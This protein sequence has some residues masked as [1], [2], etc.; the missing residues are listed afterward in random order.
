MLPV[1]PRE[2]PSFWQAP[3]IKPWRPILA[4]ILGGIGFLLSTTVVVG[5]AMLIESAISGRSVFELSQVLV[6]GGITPILFL[7][8]SASLAVLV[9][10]SLILS[11]LVGQKGG[12]LSSV[13][14]RVRWGWLAKCFLVSF[15]A[16]GALIVVST[17]LEGWDSLELSVRP[18]WWWL[19][20]GIIIVTPFQAAGE[21]YL[22]RGVLNRGIASLIPPRVAGAVVGGVVSSVVFMLL[23]GAGDVWLNITYFS[24]GMLFSYLTWRT[25]G[26]EAAVA[27]HAANNL[28]ALALLPFQDL[29]EVF[30]RSA[31]TGDPTVLLQ[32]VVLGAAAAVIVHMARRRRVS[33]TGAPAAAIPGGITATVG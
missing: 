5:V 9:P 19:L 3:G 30:N 11:R 33:R 6:D 32:L 18:G 7:A 17:T 29:N 1:E 12:W 13:V 24:M 10:L 4:I 15:G 22:I 23:H 21:E 16:I 27:M 8:N 31:G 14:G 26:L 2:Y 28:I 25:G 20:V